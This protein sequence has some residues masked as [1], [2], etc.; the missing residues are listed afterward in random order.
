MKD[1]R[2]QIV[3]AATA[4]MG[5]QGFQQ[6]SVEDGIHEAGLCGKGHFYHYFKSKEELGYAVLLHQ[7]EVFAE[8]GLEVLRERM[9]TQF[10]RFDEF[11]DWIVE[12]QAERGC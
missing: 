11:I 9:L 12:S 6:T 4:V 3:E 5:R 7:F 1:R 2:T 10:A 8:T